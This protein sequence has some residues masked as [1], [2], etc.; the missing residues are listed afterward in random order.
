MSAGDARR[1][2]IVARPGTRHSQH[3]TEGGP[4]SWIS[5]IN[6]AEGGKRIILAGTPV[7]VTGYG[8]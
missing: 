5:D 8:R 7:K 3:H 6:Y 2:S 1:A 4:G